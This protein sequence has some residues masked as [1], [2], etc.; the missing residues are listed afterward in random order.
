M[1]CLPIIIPTLNRFEHLK[2]C[3]ESLSRCKY[4]NETDLIIGLD[5]PP[6]TEY[7]EG[8]LKIKKY[9]PK[10]S[11][12]KKVIV[13][14]RESNY[15]AVLNSQELTIYA[16]QN[17]DGWI[18]TEDDNVFSPSFLEFINSSI[19]TFWNDNNV[20]SISGF[21]NRNQYNESADYI[22]TEDYSAWG[23]AIWT[24]KFEPTNECKAK[25][26]LFSTV[27]SWKIFIKYPACLKMLIDMYLKRTIY[28]DTIK[29]A[30][31][32]LNNE[33]QI[34]PAISMVRNMGHDGSGLHCG[35][36]DNGFST[37]AISTSNSYQIN[38]NSIKAY[39]PWNKQFFQGFTCNRARA[40]VSIIMIWIRY[41]KFRIQ[42]K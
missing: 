30:V 6:N 32:I 18:Y 31:N 11:G 25:M 22:L 10:I 2:N 5:F 29:T 41:V 1:R 40:I 4:A 34:R 35:E 16:K 27:K 8:Y 14:E 23:T 36:N 28:G 21:L 7:E 3:I 13:F 12:F 19:E 24:H 20:L 33:K 15:G 38:S 26:I 42:S 39:M 9:I 17:Y 37:Q